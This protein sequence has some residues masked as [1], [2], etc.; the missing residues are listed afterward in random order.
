MNEAGCTALKARIDAL[1]GE[2]DKVLLGKRVTR[3][4]YGGRLVETQEGSV[5][6]LRKRKAELERRYTACGCTPALD[7]ESVETG[8]T[9]V[10]PV[11]K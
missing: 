8:R 6:E 4:G 9:A 3:A 7:A 11:F 5:V 10:R 2:I 1:D